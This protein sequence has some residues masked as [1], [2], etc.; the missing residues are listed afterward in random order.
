MNAQETWWAGEAGNDY[1]ERNRVNWLLRV[2]FWTSIVARTGCDSV[3]EF[4]C[5]FGANLLALRVVSP[6][7]SLF[8]TDINA[9][10]VSQA[11]ALGM[12]GVYAGTTDAEFPS[13]HHYGIA[14]TAGVLIHIAP[15]DLRAK[16]ETLA[17]IGRYVL[18]IEYFSDGPEEEVIY[19]GEADRLW[20]RD[21]Q[22]L[23]EDIGLTCVAAGFCGKDQGFDDC[24][25][26]LMEKR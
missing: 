9:H 22:K 14:F 10:A 19:R 8:G 6:L 13:N 12:S 17:K 1:T 21:Y 4:G 20:K 24:N 3:F 15:A 26:S 18:A 25:W 16:M 5:N 2:P 7:I 23:Y 11:R